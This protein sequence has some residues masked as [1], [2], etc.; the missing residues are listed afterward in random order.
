MHTL[1]RFLIATL[2]LTALFLPS[3]DA[4][5]YRTT[6]QSAER[7]DEKGALY[8]I[9]YDF[10]SDKYDLY[11][12]IQVQRGTSSADGVL[13]YQLVDD[14]DGAS[15]YGKTTGIV[16]S[17]AGIRQG[18][19]FVPRGQAKRFVLVV[20]LNEVD[21][22]PIDRSLDLALQVTNL[23]FTMEALNEPMKIQGKLNPSEL[24]YYVTPEVDIPKASLR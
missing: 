4:K 1:K 7:I 23:P 2:V 15:Q 6:G 18:M 22:A 24:I 19:Y 9:A 14:R 20:V 11:L 3:T 16:L 8:T 21:G 5:A 10:G 17:D 13:S 12:P